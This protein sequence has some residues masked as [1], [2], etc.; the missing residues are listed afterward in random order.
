MYTVMALCQIQG[1]SILINRIIQK[2][3]LNVFIIQFQKRFQPLTINL[4]NFS[5]FGVLNVHS[6][7]E[8][9]NRTHNEWARPLRSQFS[10]K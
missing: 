10:W 9:K 7:M 2:D 4:E 1:L 6:L 5:S 8:K 3:F